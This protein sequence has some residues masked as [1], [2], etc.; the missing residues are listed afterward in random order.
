LPS[1]YAFF[2]CPGIADILVRLWHIPIGTLRRVFS[3]FGVERGFNFRDKAKDMT[4]RFPPPLRSLRVISQAGLARHLQHR[5]PLPLGAAYIRWYGPWVG[6]WSG[7][8]S[9]L[10]FVFT[11]YF[12]QLVS[13]HNPENTQMSSSEC[14]CSINSS[15]GFKARPKCVSRIHIDLKSE[16]RF[17]EGK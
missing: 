16:F 14:S 3:E 1:A 4:A 10:F 17:P 2:F 11:K 13:E 7:R 5:A 6:R 8:D 15:L 9:D 12:H